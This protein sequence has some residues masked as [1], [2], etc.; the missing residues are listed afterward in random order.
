LKVHI[1]EETFT[2]PVDISP[3]TFC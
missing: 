3:R 2:F 1:L